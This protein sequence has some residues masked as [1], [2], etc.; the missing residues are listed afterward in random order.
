MKRETAT[1]TF[2]EVADK[3]SARSLPLAVGEI[4]MTALSFATPPTQRLYRKLRAE[5][6]G[7]SDATMPMQP[8]LNKVL[9]D[10]RSIIDTADLSPTPL[11]DDV[12]LTRF[13]GTMFQFSDRTPVIRTAMATPYAD[14]AAIY[15]HTIE[16][17]RTDGP[18]TYIDQLEFALTQTTN[19]PTALWNLFLTSRQFARWRDEGAI[20]G[21]PDYTTE[22]KM[23]R[24]RLWDRSLA[25][26][27][28]PDTKGYQDVSGDTYYVWTH[29][30]ARTIYDGLPAEKS[31][32]SEFYKRAFTQGSRVMSL[33]RRLGAFSV[34]GTMSDHVPASEYG[35]GIGQLSADAEKKLS[36]D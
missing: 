21:M 26:C 14:V 2:I 20:K 1:P 34:F 4:A 3:L 23:N 6:D 11:L 8:P 24:M 25:A 27:K 7:S 5:F 28:A 17:A 18:Q 9:D 30:L 13:V 15:D 19:L 32:L 33:S 22:Q 35:N 16:A 29:A 31:A 36:V 12:Q 10:C